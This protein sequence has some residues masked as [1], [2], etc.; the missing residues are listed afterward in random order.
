MSLACNSVLAFPYPARHARQLLPAA[1]APHVQHGH[2]SPHWLGDTAERGGFPVNVKI[3]PP[4]GPGNLPVSPPQVI[5]VAGHL[6]PGPIIMLVAVSVIVS[7][8]ATL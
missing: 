3:P 2:L 6:S 7:V 4:D 1:R 8:I 5:H